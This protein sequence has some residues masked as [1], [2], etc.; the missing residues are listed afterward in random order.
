MDEKSLMEEI[1]GIRSK[2]DRGET[3]LFEDE[4][5]KNPKSDED[6]KKE[7]KD[8]LRKK[9]KKKGKEKEILKKEKEEKELLEKAKKML[10][11]AS[12]IKSKKRFFSP[13][14]Y[15]GDTVEKIM[16]DVILALLPAILVS[17]FL[18]GIK[19]LLLI[20]ISVVSTVLTEKIITAVF[21]K[22]E[23]NSIKDFSAV[24]TGIIF[25]LTLPVFVPYY[26]AIFGGACAVIFGKMLYGGLGKNLYNPAAV[27]K[28]FVL[29]FFE[30][31][32]LKFK[33]SN[34]NFQILDL[35]L[36]RNFLDSSFTRFLDGLILSRSN[37]IGTFSGMAL[38]F[39]GIYLVIKKRI[40]PSTPLSFFLSSIILSF[41]V[42]EIS[43]IPIGEILLVGI[44]M[45]ADMPTTPV[46]LIGKIYFGMMLA[47]VSSI[48]LSQKVQNEVLFYAI[49]I[50]NS[51]TLLIN[52]VLRP[53]TFGKN[54][55]I[56]AIKQFLQLIVLTFLIV[57]A[58]IIL[59]NLYNFGL[60][61]YLIYGYSI[62][63]I[64]TAFIFLKND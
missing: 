25:S 41:F 26:F 11:I 47:L 7:E 49:I 28:F 18:C 31:V 36:F 30:K 52:K 16:I 37:S 62:I 51:F 48:L 42:P 57:A 43:K 34:T 4:A 53:V 55:K 22:K 17:I 56:E 13:F 6:K 15:A 44:F 20:L 63:M 64:I 3:L 59:I 23:K 40:S 45:V 50:L 39:G 29:I 1:L 12:D 2:K 54:L 60:F 35:K 38:I 24:V 14:I 46:F 5:E 58:T 33:F 27:G 19:S 61:K 21:L 32:F 8:N 10:K 9:K